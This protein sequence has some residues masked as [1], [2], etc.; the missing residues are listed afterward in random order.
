MARTRIPI[1]ALPAEEQER[2][3]CL[4]RAANK[5]YYARNR[6][7][8]T[9]RHRARSAEHPEHVRRIQRAANARYLEKNRPVVNAKKREKRA[10]DP[11]H[12]RALRQAEHA[13]HPERSASH[14]RA[15]RARHPERA[16]EVDRAWKARNKATIAARDTKR[17]QEN[18]AQFLQWLRAWTQRNQEHVRAQARLWYQQHPERSKAIQARKNARRAAAPINDFTAEQWEAL[19]NAV[20]YRC[21][22]CGKAFPAE[23]LT[24][25]HLTPY[26][27]QGSNTL[28]NI[29]PCCGSCNSRKKDRPVLK[30]VQPFLLLPPEDAAAD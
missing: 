3:R 9:A 4:K 23:Q 5:R 22:Y 7:A 24:P 6:A 16:R 21:C 29:L 25:D 18:P 20:D 11:E 10:A 30:P 19:C 13:A 17:R 26:A 28:H 2:I 14:S 1:S 12:A 15:Y 8:V 27:K